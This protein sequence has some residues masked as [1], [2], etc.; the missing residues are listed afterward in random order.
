MARLH[1]LVLAIATLVSKTLGQTCAT[2]NPA[3]AP[4]FGSGFSGRVVLNGLQSPR[5]IVFDSEGNLLIV[6]SGGSGVRYVKLTDNGGTNVCV[7][8]S[9]QLIPERGVSKVF[10]IVE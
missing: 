1:Y 5:G 10:M 3:N 9:K 2:I 8:S 7:A 4:T 6:E